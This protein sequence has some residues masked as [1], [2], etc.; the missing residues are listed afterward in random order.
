MSVPIIF[1]PNDPLVIAGVIGPA[2]TTVD[3]PVVADHGPAAEPAEPAPSALQ[4][5]FVGMT[6]EEKLAALYGGECGDTKS[7]DQLSVPAQTDTS[8]IAMKSPLVNTSSDQNYESAVEDLWSS[9][10]TL[11]SEVTKEAKKRSVT[12]SSGDGKQ[13]YDDQPLVADLN[14]HPEPPKA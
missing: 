9:Y 3:D 11:T 5:S 14:P 1:D 4:D 13:S 7:F 8:P 2:A 12:L 6:L 10:F